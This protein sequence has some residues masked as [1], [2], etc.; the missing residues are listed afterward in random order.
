[1]KGQQENQYL[2]LNFWDFMLMST[3]VIVFFPWSLI[4]CLFAYGWEDTKLI[5]AALIHDAFKTLLAVVSAVILIV[6]VVLVI[7]SVFL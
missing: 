2:A 3:L 5:L 6:I 4:F 1:M 7:I